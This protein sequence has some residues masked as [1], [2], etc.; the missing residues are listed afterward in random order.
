[1]A[2][3]VQ[4]KEFRLPRDPWFFFLIFLLGH[5]LMSVRALGPEAHLWVFVLAFVLPLI[6]WFSGAPSAS[7]TPLEKEGFQLPGPGLSSLLILV[8]LLIRFWDLSGL[9]LW[10]GPDESAM[11][12]FATELSRHWSWEFFQG[13][14][15]SPPSFV[16]PTSFLLKCS[17]SPLTALWLPPAVVSLLGVGMA[18]LA[19]RQFLSKSLSF[20]IAVFMGLGYVGLLLGRTGLTLA[21]IPLWE[22]LLLYGLGRYCHKP[23]GGI[24]FLFG[25]CAGFGFNLVPFW[26]IVAVALTLLLGVVT[27]PKERRAKN[28][29]FLAGGIFLGALPF[30]VAVVREGYGGHVLKLFLGGSTEPWW[31]PLETWGSYLSFYFWGFPGVTSAPMD[32]AFFNPLMGAL[33]WVGLLELFQQ[34]KSPLVKGAF[35]LFLFF[36]LPTGLFHGMEPFRLL[37]A[38]PLFLLAAAV[39]LQ[40]LLIRVPKDRRVG[41]VVGILLLTGGIDAYRLWRPFYQVPTQ[42]EKLAVVGKIPEKYQ[43]FRIL[44][45]FK[46]REGQGLVFSE[47]VPDS[48]D[49][50]LSF[51]TAPWNAAWVD[52]NFLE[53]SKWIGLLLPLHLVPSLQGRFLDARIFPL[54]SPVQG[55]ISDHALVVLAVTPQD[56]GTFQQWQKDYGPLWD[57]VSKTLHLANGSSRHAVLEGLLDSYPSLSKD[58]L[59]QSC[60]FEKL[61]DHYSWERTFHPEDTWASWGNFG[62][63]LKD[64][65]NQSVRDK[66]LEEKY[67][68]LMAME[69]NPRP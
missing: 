52:G 13:F 35:F 50:S 49:P 8:V 25:L 51:V 54:P 45:L 55:Q 16:W 68:Q 17:F 47:L 4:K 9:F 40:T 15:Q 41:F 63:V 12:L 64:S 62:G 36:F 24:L 56:L 48:N 31:N 44:S 33:G 5:G 3:T 27:P 28:L 59:I 22:Y 2:S 14:G 18:Y 65:Y 32:L 37:P 30:L 39:G 61:L 6:L 20:T 38:L 46:D 66:V 53:E 29:G 21:W 7:S 10:P 34:Q 67:G 19:A 23:Q 43:A 60:F 42:V 58:P 1:M 11:G 26:P 69:G 57:A